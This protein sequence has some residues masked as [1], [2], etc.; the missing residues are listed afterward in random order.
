MPAII[1]T[2]G[3]SLPRNVA[4]RFPVYGTALERY[5]QIFDGVEV[6]S[7]FYRPHRS[8]TWAKWA[9]SVPPHFR[10]SVK[11]P[12]A[13]THEAKL[14]DAEELITQFAEEVRHLGNKLGFL[15]VQLPPKLRFDAAVAEPFFHHMRRSVEAK[16]ICEPRNAS[17]FADE[18]DALLTALEVS[19]VA[20]DPAVGPASAT[21]GGWQGTAYWRLHGSPDMYRSSYT[22]DA[23][24]FYERQIRD[25]L[26]EKRDIWCI[27]DNTAASEATANALSL[28]D[29]LQR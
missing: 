4:E 29:Q 17:W 22:S 2:A 7:S 11:V 18:A 15:L 13:I 25:S 26:S 27:F 28:V 10:F 20:A 12:K 6:N 24:A 23:I 5:S 1:G 16:I 21:P 9:A 19:R 3:W 8:S 14:I